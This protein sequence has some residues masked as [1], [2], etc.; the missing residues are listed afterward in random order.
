MSRLEPLWGV[1]TLAPG[2]DRAFPVELGGERPPTVGMPLVNPRHAYL[3]YA[4]W[5]IYSLILGI[6]Y[7]IVPPYVDHDFFAYIGRVCLEGGLPYRD[8][9]DMNFPGIFYVH[10][11]ALALFG[12]HNWSFLLLDYLLLIG[13]VLIVGGALARR[14]GTRTALIFIPLYQAVYATCG[15]AMSGQRDMLSMH[16]CLVAGILVLRRIETGRLGWLVL[17]GLALFCA[18]LIKPTYVLFAAGLPLVDS[19]ARRDSNPILA[20]ITLD[21]AVTALT[22][23]T[24]AA[25]LLWTAWQARV[26]ADWYECTVTFVRSSY[27]SHARHTVGQSLAMMGK[28]VIRYWPFYVAGA[29]VGGWLWL[30]SGDRALLVLLA[31]ALATAIASAL[32]QGK[33]FDYHFAT[34]LP[35]FT[36]LMAESLAWAS[37]TLAAGRRVRMHAGGL[38]AA[39]AATLLILTT[40]LAI[41]KKVVSVYRLPVAWQLGRISQDVYLKAYDLQGVPEA[42]AFVAE[43]TRPEDT[44]WIN[45]DYLIIYRLTHRRSPFRFSHPIYYLLATPPFPG[46]TRWQAEVAE[47]LH[48]RPPKLIIMIHSKSYKDHYDYFDESTNVPMIRILRENMGRRYRLVKSIDR[49]DIYELTL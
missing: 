19:A 47:I 6:L 2:G 13:F 44:V 15:N 42:V 49:F 21:G 5:A 30:R 25:V 10:A 32:L 34:I 43:H 28:T 24:L 18:A 45:S 9:A 26:L 14:Q 48:E 20:R 11:L 12:A 36:V 29:A 37:R 1:Q 17:A 40:V 23:V 41:G 31:T 3:W 22:M 39:V 8:A 4:S 7:L 46:A 35:I 38:I 16:L 27:G 33:M